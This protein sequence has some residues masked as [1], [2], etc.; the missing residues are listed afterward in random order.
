VASADAPARA[1][2]PARP[3]S[4][5]LKAA[6]D[7]AERAAAG[8]DTD[9]AGAGERGAPAALLP[10]NGDALALADREREGGD[11]EKEAESMDGGGNAA[12]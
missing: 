9:A 1:T 2:P 11:D 4:D 6:A 7:D 3:A 5:A 12:G 8:S 10:R